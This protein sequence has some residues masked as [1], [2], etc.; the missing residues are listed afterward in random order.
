MTDDCPNVSPR[1]VEL[2]SELIDASLSNDQ[3]KELSEM[4]AADGN[5]RRFGDR[6]RRGCNMAGRSASIAWRRNWS[7]TYRFDRAA[8]RGRRMNSSDSLIPSVRF[9]RWKRW[10]RSGEQVV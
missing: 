6:P 2:V 7:T 3:R 8:D 9:R 1:V 4:L 10:T 5:S